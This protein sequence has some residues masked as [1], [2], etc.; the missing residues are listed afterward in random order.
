MLDPFS[1]AAPLRVRT[2]VVPL[3]LTLAR[4]QE[5]FGQLLE[6]DSVRLGDVL[7]VDGVFLPQGYPNGHVVFDFNTAAEEEDLLFLHDFEPWRKTF[8]VVGVAQGHADASEVARLAKRF[9]AAAVHNVVVFDCDAPSLQDVLSVPTRPLTQGLET[10]VCD[11]ARNFLALLGAYA[12]LYLNITLRLPG[13]MSSRRV[14]RAPSASGIRRQTL[15]LLALETRRNAARAKGRQLKISGHL[16]LLAGLYPLALKDFSEAVSHLRVAQDHL[17]LGSALEG[18]AV[19]VVLLANLNAP[20]HLSD[21][22]LPFVTKP[23]LVLPLLLLPRPLVLLPRNLTALASPGAGFQV[24]ILLVP[25]TVHQL[26]LKSILRY[27]MTSDQDEDYVPQRVYCESVLRIVKF[28]AAVHTGGWGRET[29]AHIVTGGPLPTATTATMFSKQEISELMRSLANCGL[30]DMEPPDQ[31]R[32][33]GALAAVYG[34]LGMPRKR[35]FMLHLLFSQVVPRMLLQASSGILPLLDSLA[36]VYRASS[37]R[38]WVAVAHPVVLSCLAVCERDGSSE[39]VVSFGLMLLR[40]FVSAMLGVEQIKVFH[41]VG[42]AV[43][44]LGVAC[45]F[46]GTALADSVVVNPPASASRLRKHQQTVLRLV[47]AIYNPFAKPDHVEPDR[48]LLIQ[49][50]ACEVVVRVVNPYAFDLELGEVE[51]LST[52]EFVTQVSRAGGMHVLPAKSSTDLLLVVVPQSPGESVVEGIRGRVACCDAQEFR[53]SPVAV[54]VAPPQPQLELASVLLLNGRGMLLEGETNR[55]TL[56][57]TNDLA[58]PIDYFRCTVRDLTVVPLTQAL[59]V[60][61]QPPH[62]VYEIEYYL[63]KRPAMRVVDQVPQGVIP[64]HLPCTM[65]VALSGK[66]GMRDCTMSIEYAVGGQEVKFTS[67]LE[68]PVTVSVYP[69]LELAGCD[70]LPLF[71]PRSGET[72]PE[73]ALLWEFLQTRVAA[74]DRALD[75]CIMVVDLR[76]AWTEQMAVELMYGEAFLLRAEVAPR[77]THRFLIPIRRI[78]LLEQQLE[79][80]IPSLRNRQTVVDLRVL[81]L[82]MEF[83]RQAF[84][85]RNHLLESVRGSW[86]E[87]ASGRAGEVELRGIRLSLAMVNILRVDPVSLLVQVQGG[88]VARTGMSWSVPPEEFFEV[89]TEVRNE[90]EYA[91]EAV[92]RHTPTVQQDPGAPIS[93]KVLF[94]GVLQR[95][96]GVLQPGEA[97]QTVVGACILDR[98]DYEWGVVLE[99]RRVGGGEVRVVAQLEPVLLSVGV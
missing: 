86:T 42:D 34:D 27:D 64:P 4:F 82:E 33:Y 93:R 45:A 46:W 80:P 55:F 47:L 76:N 12:R 66:R 98:G 61:D 37:P 78:G 52:G 83:I 84:W 68:V 23:T 26:A 14:L 62:E 95:S 88:R 20:A 6:V 11:V 92:V 18:I 16:Y 10:V 40:H 59:A 30:P 41:A 3:G 1:F 5:L 49:G 19:T 90:R 44:R 60:K 8:V 13:T 24:D 21:T 22:V 28:M 17:W 71:F 74:G 81:K 57:L 53:V 89:H 50:E 99:E 38:A 69:S 29:L 63:L 75:Y 32:V 7:P 58:V 67:V 65:E 94:N 70:F 48:V 72:Y 15:I 25:E 97:V 43:R 79:E 96:I 85:Y 36:K 35:G 9:P 2:L 56:Q 51:V 91:I 87:P 39:G 77:A 31:C 73:T 54:V